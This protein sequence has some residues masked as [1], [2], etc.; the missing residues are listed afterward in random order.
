MKVLSLIIVFIFI[1]AGTACSGNRQDNSAS[2]IRDRA[3]SAYN[4]LDAVPQT[5]NP[6][7]PVPKAQPSVIP[8]NVA[9]PVIM[10]LP[11]VNGKGTNSLQQVSNNPFAKS[12]MNGIV[13][14][15]MQRHYEVKSLEGNSELQNIIQMQTD[16]A[17]NDEDLAYLASLALNADIYIKYFGS[18][19][20]KGFV[21]VNLSVYESTTARQIGSYS[22]SVDSHGR[23]S[24][25]DQ[26]ANLKT[27]AKKA[28]SPIEKQIHSYW[29]DDIRLGTQFKV[30]INITGNYD[31]S[32]IED[33]H[34][35]IRQKLKTKFN[36]VRVNSMTSKTVDLVV[37]ADPAQYEDVSEVY[38]AIRQAIRPFAETKKL[39]I[40]KKLIIMELK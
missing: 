22:S 6:G 3:N 12:V 24:N 39:N 13:D 21:T 33:L 7:V 14:Y 38:S 29:M 19:D 27:A 18:M 25:I 15:L 40:T 20:A 26:Q 1:A 31:D 5:N 10:V 36:K 8:E 30:I 23:T 4:E 17:G 11:S 37:Y 32:A 16:I 35:Q 2:A 28:M 9:K 34:D